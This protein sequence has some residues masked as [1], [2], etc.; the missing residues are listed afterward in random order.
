[1]IKI[2]PFNEPIIK[3]YPENAYI[4]SILGLSEA[5]Y[6]TIFESFYSINIW[7]N[8]NV[9]NGENSVAFEYIDNNNWSNLHS[10]DY[11]YLP[12]NIV[13]NFNNKC[14][15][16]FQYLISHEYYILCYIDEYFI[17]SYKAYYKTHISHNLM[18][19]GFDNE[20]KVFLCADFFGRNFMSSEIREIEIEEAVTQYN[21]YCHTKSPIGWVGLK[22]KQEVSFTI[23]FLQIKENLT[24]MQ[25]NYANTYFSCH[26]IG[27]LL[28]EKKI[29]MMD[30][31]SV[32]DYKMVWRFWHLIYETLI[33]MH[34]RINYLQ[35]FYNNELLDVVEHKGSILL[36]EAQIA[37]NRYIYI[38]QKF[39]KVPH[40]YFSKYYY[41]FDE[42]YNKYYDF[43]DC[44]VGYCESMI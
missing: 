33:L 42:I 38:L 19:Y 27:T 43:L 29:I 16:V 7:R 15:P 30:N 41:I 22:K 39:E 20:K 32:A 26:G 9:K 44:F 40:K 31:L 12:S 5:F 14:I 34:Y 1:M 23:D 6:K 25:T 17:S 4:F 35:N 28:F 24:S 11:L 3:H 18:I 36:K 10:F 8:N 13:E 21:K 2:L 37:R